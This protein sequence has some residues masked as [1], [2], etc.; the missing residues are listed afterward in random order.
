MMDYNGA[1]NVFL[2]YSTGTSSKAVYCK[3]A[4]QTET[5]D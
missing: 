1:D 2:I 3:G 5:R 4:G